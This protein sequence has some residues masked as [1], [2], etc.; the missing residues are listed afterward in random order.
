MPGN[1]RKLVGWPDDRWQ[2]IDRVVGEVF[3]L[4][5]WVR[6][7]LPDGPEPDSS[8]A[9]SLP[10]AVVTGDVGSPVELN[11]GKTLPPVHLKHTL[12]LKPDQLEDDDAIVRLVRSAATRVAQAEDAVL[13]LGT[14]ARKE[15]G[16]LGVVSNESLENQA[17]L[18][19]AATT[20]NAGQGPLEAVVAGISELESKG[21]VG[22]YTAVLSSG[23]WRESRLPLPGMAVIQ[24]EQ[25]QHALGTILVAGS[26]YLPDG[27]RAVV[28]SRE[29]WGYDLVVAQ[30]PRV[31]FE[32]WDE[33]HLIL[34]VD[35]R[36]LLRIIDDRTACVVTSDTKH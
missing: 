1:N 4:V 23:D 24:L 18:L 25:I 8:Y 7:I 11:T 29:E 15:L 2:R 20:T 36:F 3:E 12:R 34:R 35:E 33:G 27:V 26:P 21:F 19:R 14:E 16:S 10:K 9:I 31:D 17:G 5:P 30:K 32:G 6:Q 13:L 28:L 22:T